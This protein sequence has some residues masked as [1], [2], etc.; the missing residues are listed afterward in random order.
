MFPPLPL[1]FPS[2]CYARGQGFTNAE[3]WALPPLLFFSPYGR[4]GAPP[5][6]LFMRAQEMIEKAP[7]KDEE[8][9]SSFP[10]PFSPP[11]A[12]CAT[13]RAPPSLPPH[14]E[15]TMERNLNY[16]PAGACRR[17]RV[18]LHPF[19]FL[20]FSPPRRRPPLPPLPLSFFCDGSITVFTGKEELV[21]GFYSSSRSQQRIFT[22][23]PFSSSTVSQPNEGTPSFLSLFFPLRPHRCADFGLDEPQSGLADE[24]IRTSSFFPFLL[25]FSMS[26]KRIF[27]PSSFLFFSAEGFPPTFKVLVQ[28]PPFSFFF[29]SKVTGRRGLSPSLL[30]PFFVRPPS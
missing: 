2:R 7:V 19:L 14:W 26:L 6:F 4:A 1:F 24:N 9:R 28:G 20:L 30:S 8:I 12:S 18:L 15:H 21:S 29:S 11:S 5:F 22:F 3:V 25:L 10:P 13:V 17:R 23:P 16:R 27:S